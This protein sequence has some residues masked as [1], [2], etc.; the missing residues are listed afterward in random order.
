MAH[1]H[2]TTQLEG[3]AGKFGLDKSEQTYL[4]VLA[5]AG[6]KPIRLNVL[7]TRLGLPSKTISSVI[8]RF[9]VREGL[10]MRT[11]TGRILTE[12]GHDYVRSSHLVDPSLSNS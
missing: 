1:L 12:K 6:G 11:D 10:V 3:L 7:A 2:R 8:E 5:D 9:L 4:R